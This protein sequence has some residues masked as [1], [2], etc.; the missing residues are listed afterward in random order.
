M[1]RYIFIGVCIYISKHGFI[2]IIWRYRSHI[3][4]QLI[5]MEFKS[6]AIC[7]VSILVLMILIGWA[8]PVIPP[9]RQG[10]LGGS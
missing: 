10:L 3:F 6:K 1:Y 4:A 5:T 8:S 2:N 9:P 7:E